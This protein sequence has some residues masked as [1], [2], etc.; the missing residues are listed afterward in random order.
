LAGDPAAADLTGYGPLPA[1]LARDLLTPTDPQD[2]PH[3]DDEAGAGPQDGPG[4]EQRSTGTAPV[5]CPAGG[6]CTDAACTAVHGGTPPGP[7]LATPPAGTASSTP[8]TGTAG[9]G[10][11]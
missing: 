8:P 1:D 9:P 3:V 11:R 5:P 10:E 4:E 7:P 2:D 6:R